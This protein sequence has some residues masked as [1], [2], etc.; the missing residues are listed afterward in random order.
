MIQTKLLLLFSLS[1]SINAF[2][3]TLTSNRLSTTAVFGW[4]NSPTRRL[5]DEEFSDRG[6]GKE[7]SYESMDD[8]ELFRAGRTGKKGERKK[9]SERSSSDREAAFRAERDKMYEFARASGLL[10]KMKQ[11]AKER[12][13]MIEE[14]EYD[15]VMDGGFSSDLYDEGD[16]LDVR[17]DFSDDDE[18]KK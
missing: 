10:D 8:S 2:V 4:G 13:E 3:P 16:D 9:L 12:D 1:S 15:D 6:E 7:S 11:E 5:R 14:G 18:K 17:V